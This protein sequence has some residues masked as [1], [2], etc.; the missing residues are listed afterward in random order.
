V[1]QSMKLGD[2][3]PTTGRCR[4]IPESNSE[5]ELE[6]DTVIKAIGQSVEVPKEFGLA[7]D[8]GGRIVVRD[9]TYETSLKGVWAGGDAVFGP[10][11]VVEAIRDGRKAASLIDKYLGGKGLPEPELDP[12]EFVSKPLLHEGTKV[13]AKS[14]P[15]PARIIT[16]DDEWE[17]FEEVE[18]GLCSEEAIA[19]ASRCWRC[20]WN[21]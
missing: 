3:D 21:E 12:G 2:I 19:E 13:K 14:D 4:F 5:F 10:T 6:A 17:V 7:V 8:R 11:S 18:V 16:T 1:F 20:D 9:G 15:I